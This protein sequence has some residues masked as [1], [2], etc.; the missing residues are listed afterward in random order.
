[1][2]LEE[3]KRLLLLAAGNLVDKLVD[4]SP[5]VMD[6]DKKGKK[7]RKGKK[8][9]KRRKASKEDGVYMNMHVMLCH[10]VCY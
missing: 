1:M 3:R 5:C 4:M 8:R 9:S 2:S 6:D 10:L 7:R